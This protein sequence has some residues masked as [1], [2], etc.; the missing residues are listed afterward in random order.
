MRI[1]V[2]LGEPFWRE[3][4]AKEVTLDLPEGAKVADLLAVLGQRFPS[5]GEIMESAELPPTVFLGDRLADADTPLTQGDRP[6]LVWAMA[7]G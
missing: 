1:T 6:T 5:L 3:I 7:G 2:S 4:Q